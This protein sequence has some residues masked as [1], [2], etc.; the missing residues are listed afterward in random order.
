MIY[1][2]TGDGKGKTTAAIGAGIRALGNKKRVLMV[3]FMKVKELTSEY[4]IIQFLEGFDM[5]S[6]G[7]EGFY[8][9]AEY[10][11]KHPEAKKFGVKPFSEVDYK[12]AQDGIDFV[13]NAVKKEKYYLIILDEICVAVSLGLIKKEAVI[14]I[15]K[16][17]SNDIHFILTGRNCPDSIKNIA[18]LVT[19]MKDIKHYFKKGKKA[20]KGIDF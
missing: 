20:V 16:K 4:K 1:V 17:Y 14:D 13:L 10:L 12:L 6:F 15:L 5:E 7:R 19:E 2:Y 11:E 8:M 9:P 3:Q 18:D